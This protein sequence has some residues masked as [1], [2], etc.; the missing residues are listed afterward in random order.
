ML[1]VE[2]KSPGTYAAVALGM[3]AH[4]VVAPI[5]LDDWSDVRH[6]HWLAFQKLIGVY[7]EHGEAEA[8]KAVAASCAYSQD[9][10]R[11]SLIGARLDGHLAG[12][13]GWKPADDA[14]ASPR[15]TPIAPLLLRANSRKFS[16]LAAAIVT[17]WIAVTASAGLPPMGPSVT[18]AFAAARSWRPSASNT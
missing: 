1:M 18:W 17:P 6:L 9:L 4:A 2:A 12:T 15:R 5:G 16:R 10:R 7:L 8:F 14:G 3:A 11:A 13:C